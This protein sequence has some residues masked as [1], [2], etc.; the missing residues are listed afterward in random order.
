[1]TAAADRTLFLIWLDT[2]LTDEDCTPLSDLG[3]WFLLNEN[4]LLIH[5]AQTRSKV[6]HAVKHMFQ[7]EALMAAPLKDAPKFKGMNEG[8]LNW[9]RALPEDG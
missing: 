2:S 3:S 7:P 5:S 4:L 8:A 9:V 6:Y 1:M